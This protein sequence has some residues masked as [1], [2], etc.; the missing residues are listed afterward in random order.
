MD[1]LHFKRLTDPIHGTFGI[2]KLEA[3]II[4]TA[5][6]Q[7]LHNVRQLGLAHLVF[8]GAGYSRFSHSL[9]ACHIAGK[10]VR[11]INQNTEGEPISKAHE[12]LYRVA[13]LLHDIGHY[14]FSHAME[15]SIK[16][17]YTA[18]K[19]MVVEKE[20]GQPKENEEP[21][22]KDEPPPYYGHEVLGRAI[23]DY[24]SEIGAVLKRNRVS[25]EE[26]KGVYSRENPDIL[27]N[28]V[29]SDL[30]CDRLD[31]LLRTANDAGMPYGSIDI[32]YLTSQVCLD[33]DGKVCLTRKALKAADHFLIS[34][35]FDY[36]Q[37]VF[38][39]T[40]VGLEEALK[41]VIAE[42]IK[43]NILDC[44]GASIKKQIQ[45]DK[46]SSFDDQ[47]LIATIREAAA[48]LGHKDKIFKRKA[49]SVL[50]RDA[51]KLVA[52]SEIIEE[53]DDEQEFN[54]HVDQMRKM[55]PHL[56]KKFG[57]E[58]PLWHLWQR[59]LN[60]TKVGSHVPFGKTLDLEEE[61]AQV[62][63]VL[64]CELD[65]KK[66]ESKSLLEHDFALTKQLANIGLFCIRLYVHLPKGGDK[67][68]LRHEISAEI[69]K[70]LPH[71][72]FAD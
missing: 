17:F 30:D 10:M 33:S 46:F 34:R 62:V 27:T 1:K 69:R 14:P 19:H 31:Y 67:K 48:S 52:S 57:I 28:L 5:A 61:A 15:H 13:G 66:R 18:Q 72:P 35:Y 41:D 25:K 7:R 54:N 50:F 29:S 38:H 32:E 22:G 44:S 4:S 47:Y 36:T 21:K 39:K 20:G 8:P 43:K 3:E 2:S 65:A 37:L 63:R 40:V 51:P 71:F 56:A 68:K 42:L 12:Q 55:I 49:E 11:A 45:E 24:D 9:G 64:T 26:L 16:N 58:E 6:F 53:R 60:I 23:I 70:E 59:S